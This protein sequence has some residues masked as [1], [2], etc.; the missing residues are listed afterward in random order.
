MMKTY[1]RS[2]TRARDVLGKIGGFMNVLNRFF[3]F[4]GTYFSAKF[5][6]SSLTSDLYLQK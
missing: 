3:G 4:L 5:V 1:D 2:V 6:A